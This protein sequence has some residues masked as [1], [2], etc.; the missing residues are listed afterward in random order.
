MT[1]L[2][3][4][5]NFQSAADLLCECVPFWEIGRMSSLCRIWASL[6]LAIF[7]S[8]LRPSRSKALDRKDRKEKPA[9]LTKKNRLLPPPSLHRGDHVRHRSIRT[10]RL[11]LP[12]QNAR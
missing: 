3:G 6:S 4:K 8:P 2:L 9:K 10:D 11:G 5:M 12:T 7:A 1:V